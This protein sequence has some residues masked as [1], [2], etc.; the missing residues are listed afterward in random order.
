MK[1]DLPSSSLTENPEIIQ[2][3]IHQFSQARLRVERIRT[4]TARLDRSKHANRLGQ[5]AK[6]DANLKSKKIQG[7]HL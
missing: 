5:Q 6:L 3:A 4:A 2:S 7:K 1:P